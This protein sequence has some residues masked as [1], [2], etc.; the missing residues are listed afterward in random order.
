MGRWAQRRRAGGGPGAAIA[1]IHLVAATVTGAATMTA[2]YSGPPDISGLDP[3]DFLAVING[4]N[5]DD[6]A[7]LGGNQIQI[8]FAGS[9]FGETTLEY[10]GTTPGY[11]TPDSVAVT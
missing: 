6:I 11:L 8:H 3:T 5:G 9:I 2:T 7:A 1:I 10:S 4:E